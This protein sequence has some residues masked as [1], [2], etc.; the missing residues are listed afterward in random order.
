MNSVFSFLANQTWSYR[1]TTVY[2]YYLF[3]K[4]VSPQ[5]PTV[6]RIGEFPAAPPL[7]ERRPA[8]KMFRLCDRREG[9]SPTWPPFFRPLYLALIFGQFD[10]PVWLR[11]ASRATDVRRPRF[12]LDKNNELACAA[13]NL[14][15]RL[16]LGRRAAHRLRRPWKRT[17]SPLSRNSRNKAP[18]QPVILS[19]VCEKCFADATC[20]RVCVYR[21]TTG[22]DQGR[23]TH[24][25]GWKF[26]AV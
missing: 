10:K 11:V 23:Q 7:P 19:R 24:G 2:A 3:F 5:F 14:K 18:P 12:A 15:H 26:P 16:P 9:P 4:N 13:R 25:D 20:V 8:S 1:S 21:E 22:S 6:F 17:R